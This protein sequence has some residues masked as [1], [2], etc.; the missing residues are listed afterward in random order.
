[1]DKALGVL[2]PGPCDTNTVGLFPAS[3][4]HGCTAPDTRTFHQLDL[5]Q[6]S[7]LWLLRRALNLLLLGVFPC[8]DPST[9]LL[10]DR[11]EDLLVFDH[12]VRVV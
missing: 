10:I 9:R 6:L 1:M 4:V 7:S 12:V 11:P 5:L 8:H 2:S 3:P